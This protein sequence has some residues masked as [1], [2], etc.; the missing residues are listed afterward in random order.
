[1]HTRTATLALLVL[2][3]FGGASASDTA[4]DTARALGREDATNPLFEEW[5]LGQMRPAFMPVFQTGLGRCA[6]LARGRE[7]VS[8][9]LVFV[10]RADGS[11]GDFFASDNT[12][13]AS[14]LEDTIR[15]Q[16]YPAAPKEE[17]YFGL[18]LAPQATNA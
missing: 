14:C 11:V 18:D 1:M 2:A 15:R 3:P 7:L 4:F 17:F 6:S 12:R 8:L 13:F 16:T 10:V 9:G 5:Y